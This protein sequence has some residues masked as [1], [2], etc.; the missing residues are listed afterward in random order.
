[1]QAWTW[2]VRNG[3]RSASTLLLG[4]KNRAAI[5]LH[6]AGAGLLGGVGQGLSGLG[7]GA[8]SSMPAGYNPN[9]LSGLY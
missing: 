4:R 6:G 8:K 5:G 1:M 7:S 3:A 2:G 9:S